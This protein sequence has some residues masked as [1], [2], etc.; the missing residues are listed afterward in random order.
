MTYLLYGP[1]N[2]TELVTTR[3][4]V[5]QATIVEELTPRTIPN[6]ELSYQY[7]VYKFHIV[8]C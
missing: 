8:L 7:N 2:K 3:Y 6:N 5:V 1:I 4:D